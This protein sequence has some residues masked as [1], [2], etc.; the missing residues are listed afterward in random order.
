VKFFICLIFSVSFFVASAQEKVFNDSLIAEILQKE[1]VKIGAKL[2]EA[3]KTGKIKAYRTDSLDK[4]ISVADLNKLTHNLSSAKAV[5]GLETFFINK[6][7]TENINQ[8]LQLAGIAPLYNPNINGI[9]L[10]QQAMCFFTFADMEKVLFAEDVKLVV[11]LSKLLFSTHNLYH[12]FNIGDVEERQKQDID[13]FISNQVF[14]NIY[15]TPHHV[16]FTQENIKILATNLIHKTADV[17]FKSIMNY[18]NGSFSYNFDN[19]YED[20]QLKNQY[21]AERWKE[22]NQFCETVTVSVGPDEDMFVDS[23]ICTEFDYY[24][25]NKLLLS[26][27]A[28]GFGYDEPDVFGGRKIRIYVPRKNLDIILPSWLSFLINTYLK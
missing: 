15:N 19:I 23:T 25:I 18:K 1:C 5:N 26:P 12:T 11:I 4:T 28:L 7:T 14:E 21:T 22:L 8:N 9:E 10:P 13:N 24:S 3:A 20:A 27:V 16:F 6:S 2:L 17:Y